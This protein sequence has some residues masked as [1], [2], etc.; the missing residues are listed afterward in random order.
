MNYKGY[1]GKIVD[2]DEDSGMLHGRVLGIRGVITFEALTVAG[3]IEAFMGSV[4]DYLVFCK[5][6]GVEPS[7]PYSGTFN[8]RLAPDVHREVALAAELSQ[9]SMNEW[10]AEKLELA[11]HPKA[12]ATE[13]LVFSRKAIEKKATKATDSRHQK[14]REAKYGILDPATSKKIVKKYHAA[15]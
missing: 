8:V 12:S 4:D 5:E 2:V 11:A 7:K 6:E 15:Q 3:A 13:A 14:T 10:V 9:K 1:T